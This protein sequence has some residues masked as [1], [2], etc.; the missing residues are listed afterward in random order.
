MGFDLAKEILQIHEHLL[1]LKTNPT[2]KLRKPYHNMKDLHQT[3]LE[4]YK[5][6]RIQAEI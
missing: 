4:I 1:E 3:P 2:Q 6:R 5:T